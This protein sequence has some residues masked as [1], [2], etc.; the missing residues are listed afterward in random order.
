VT[1][2]IIPV[3]VGDYPVSICCHSDSVNS[4]ELVKATK[5]VVDEFNDQYFPES[6]VE[7]ELHE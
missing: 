4:V 3:G 7:N 1:G 5:A 2:E 6:D